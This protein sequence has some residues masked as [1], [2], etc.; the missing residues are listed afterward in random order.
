MDAD[1]IDGSVLQLRGLLYQAT[2]LVAQVR[3]L[4]S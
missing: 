2:G 4:S 3:I 1:D